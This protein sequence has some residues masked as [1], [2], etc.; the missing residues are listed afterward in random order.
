MSIIKIDGNNES[1]FTGFKLLHPGA[2]CF[3]IANEPEVKKSS[4][5]N[6]MIAVELRCADDGEFKGCAVF[7]NIAITPRSEFRVCHLAL[8]AGTQDKEDIKSRGVDLSLLPG[9]IVEAEIGIQP[10]R[11]DP[12]TGNTYREKNIVRRYIF[13]AD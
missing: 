6:P 13:D 12:A 8:A 3:E 1:N 4:K 10:A 9:K 5:G 2:Y 7:D 11:M